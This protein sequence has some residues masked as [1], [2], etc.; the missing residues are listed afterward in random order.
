MLKAAIHLTP[1]VLELGGKSPAIVDRNSDLKVVG[2]RLAW[3]KWTN[4]GQTC[5]APDYVMCERD[6]QDKLAAEIKTA[7]EEFFSTKPKESTQY[8]RLVNGR[9]FEDI[10]QMIASTVAAAPP[11]TDSKQTAPAPR[12]LMGGLDDADANDKYIAPT[13]IADVNEKSSVM[14]KE[15]FGPILPI[16]PVASIDEAIKYV[17]RNEKPLA[18]YVF[19]NDAKV[20]ERVLSSTSSGGALANDTLMHAGVPNLP[21]GGVGH[22]GTGAYHGKAT[23]DA[24]SHHRSIMIK[25]QGMEGV[26]TIRY[27]PYTDSK[28]KWI[29]RLFVVQPNGPYH[30]A[31]RFLFRAAMIAGLAAAAL[32]FVPMLKFK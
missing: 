14:Q 10:K 18:L 28:A 8:G 5:V 26:N 27:P 12:V 30:N 4:C 19:S 7:A 13:M 31:K 17:N 16:M 20:C 1:V 6:V 24:F 29:N 25:K 23:F 15:I 22:S 32:R 2:R 11:D 3:G 9:R 21:F